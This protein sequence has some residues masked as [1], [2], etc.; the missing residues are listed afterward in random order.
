MAK[1]V[2][3]IVLDALKIAA[4]KFVKYAPGD[5]PVCQ[6][7]VVRDGRGFPWNKRVALHPLEDGKIEMLTI[8]AED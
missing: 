1:P 2:I 3:A 4:I 8:Q 6:T 7:R 5:I